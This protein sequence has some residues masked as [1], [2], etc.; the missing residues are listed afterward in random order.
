MLEMFCRTV[1]WRAN[2][3]SRGSRKRYQPL[4]AANRTLCKCVVS[5]PNYCIARFVLNESGR[6]EL[7]RIENAMWF[8]PQDG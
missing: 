3:V 7:D 1:G 8:L 4:G 2:T 5:D 6:S